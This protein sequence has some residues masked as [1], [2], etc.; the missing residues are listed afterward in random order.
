MKKLCTKIREHWWLLL[1]L[2]LAPMF[3]KS[4]TP[5]S[6][7]FFLAATGRWIVQ[8]LAVPTIN[9]F[10]IHEGFE[11]VVQQWLYDVGVYFVYEYFGNLGLLVM[12]ILAYCL[13]L[14][15]LRKYVTLFT[16]NTTVHNIATVF[17][18]IAILP[19]VTARPSSI[20]MTLMLAM[21]YSLEQYKRTDKNKYLFYMLG[22]S[23][24]QINVHAS[25]WPMM[26]VFCI[27]YFFIAH[28][29]NHQ[30]KRRLRVWAKRHW[31]LWL[32]MLGMVLVA[33]INPY[34]LNG[35]MYVFRSYGAATAI[36]IDEVNPPSFL[37]IPWFVIIIMIACLVVT[38]YKPWRRHHYLSKN[39][40]VYVYLALG[41]ILLASM[42]YRNNWYCT[43][44]CLPVMTWALN[45]FVRKREVMSDGP[46]NIAK[47]FATVLACI[48]LCVGGLN[49]ASYQFPDGVDT[50]CTPVEAVEYLS[51]QKDV[52]LFTEFNNGAYFE[53][54]GYEVYFDARPELFDEKING[55]EDVV[56]EYMAAYD[57]TI[58]YDEF[59]EKYKFTHIV[60]YSNEFVDYLV[61]NQDYVCVVAND[62]YAM[63]EYRPI[64]T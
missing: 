45:H 37:S 16:P 34:G 10:V 47:A 21:L 51:T 18:G 54:H 30:W 64:I 42:H 29:P 41:T 62:N 39:T 4:S 25:M 11:I 8:N 55:K 22:L 5:N 36:V 50:F 28:I 17:A 19:F 6:D 27:P 35:M 14:F 59:V 40:M 12:T 58:N 3:I 23:M 26:L 49:I 7:T 53:W 38:I 48:M 43:I 20:T 32:T 44:G 56:S 9:P 57:G 52:K 46:A 63:F 33:L 15:M 24:L 61:T 2:A 13:T 60:T 1:L 31:K